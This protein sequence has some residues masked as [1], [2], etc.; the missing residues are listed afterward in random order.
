MG[1]AEAGPTRRESETQA[2]S[3]G[4]G[5]AEEAY[6]TRLR[7]GAGSSRRGLSVHPLG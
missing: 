1:I 5:W 2:E 7:V 3:R 4:E 6:R